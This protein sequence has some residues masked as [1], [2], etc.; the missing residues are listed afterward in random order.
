MAVAKALQW[1]F[2]AGLSGAG[3][4]AGGAGRFPG[5]AKAGCAKRIAP[6][7]TVGKF[8]LGRGVTIKTPSPFRTPVFT[9]NFWK[10]HVQKLQVAQIAGFAFGHLNAKD[11]H[12]VFGIAKDCG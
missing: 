2:L 10:S 1:P 9:H 6:K 11:Y 3:G 12:L 5:R 8:C 4:L 7:N